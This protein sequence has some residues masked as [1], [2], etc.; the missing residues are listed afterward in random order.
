MPGSRGRF[1]P[2]WLQVRLRPGRLTRMWHH[3]DKRPLIAVAL[4]GAVSFLAVTHIRPGTTYHAG[5]LARADLYA[6]F[7]QTW[8]DEA[9]TEQT[10]A[11]ARL[12]APK[13][14]VAKRGEAGE[15]VLARVNTLF[16]RVEEAAAAIQ[17]TGAPA[18]DAGPESAPDQSP[19]AV[20]SESYAD[21]T[22][23]EY[24]DL[25]YRAFVTLAELPA[26]ERSATHSATVS[27]LLAIN[28]EQDLRSDEIDQFTGGVRRV[29]SGYANERAFG[30]PARQEAAEA[31]VDA[32]AACVLPNL[33][34]ST[35][36]TLAAREQ[37]A[38]S[39][40]PQLVEVRK[41][42]RLLTKHQRVTTD[43]LEKLSK[44]GLARP[45]IEWSTALLTM[46]LVF[47]S[48]SAG[49][50][51]LHLFE[52][53]ALRGSR[54]LG[55]LS[56]MILVPA[57]VLNL[58][59]GEQEASYFAFAVGLLTT[60][61]ATVL[62]G[63]FSATVIS[64]G[65]LLVAALV[66][67]PTHT[68]GLMSLLVGAVTGM[69]VAKRLTYAVAQ[70]VPL[71]LGA[72]LV[73]FCATMLAELIFRRDTGEMPV[74][75]A[76]ELLRALVW[77][78][79]AGLAG[80]FGGHSGS[81][82]LEHPLGTVTEMRLL[83]LSDPRQP[84]LQELLSKAP[85]TYHGS[86]VVSGLAGNAAQASGQSERDTLLVR[87]GGLYHDIGK[88][89]RPHM[90]VENQH[91]GHNPHD[92]IAPELSAR[93]IMSHITDGIELAQIH[94]L[95]GPVLE[96]IREHHGTT[97]ISYFYQRA[98]ESGA[99]DVEESQ[100]RYPGPK[101]QSAATGI[102]MLSDGVEAAVRAIRNPTRQ[103]IQE[104]V[105]RIVRSRFE[106]GQLDECPLTIRQIRDI[107]ESM[108]Q[109]LLGIY[110]ARIEYPRPTTPGAPPADRDG[111][112]VGHA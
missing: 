38:A 33:E 12:S 30:L 78:A 29:L 87:V 15:A 83:E 70:I 2:R 92:G 101:P 98:L 19:R 69:V 74:Q 77:S 76:S 26:P 28:N 88:L 60:L 89:R 32:A 61:A 44:L 16:G 112:G 41:G 6:P 75:D 51:L 85:G 10:R 55:A 42:D 91:G 13:Q 80:V 103:M 22:A 111:V 1:R 7:D 102:L 25:S 17:W 90:F 72:G 50:L 96:C 52:P 66:L 21:L 54:R 104:T 23:S 46:A 73:A 62:L 40:Q 82:Y 84:V 64:G 63:V 65:L 71:G 68:V 43:D 56:G 45:R 95:P 11:Q 100:Y 99:P 34:Y 3:L 20:L 110:H 31:F 81:R 37:A 24:I 79:G 48:L 86:L 57:L 27:A 93:A 97:L 108:T 107:E 58:V 49:A 53:A 4:F 67:Q 105:T 94:H 5:D 106:D 8:V 14:Y 18:P 47:S 39:V 36:Q 35:E 109:T 9:A 59:A